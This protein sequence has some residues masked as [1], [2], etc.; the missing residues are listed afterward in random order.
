MVRGQSEEVASNT[1]RPRAPP[2]A[3]AARQAEAGLR[4][5]SPHRYVLLS[6]VESAQRALITPHVISGTAFCH[7]AT[8]TAG[9]RTSTSR[10]RRGDAITILLV[11]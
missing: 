6:F 3:R 9:F 8:D 4:A 5:A 2:L 7:Y 11:I 10:G 1:K